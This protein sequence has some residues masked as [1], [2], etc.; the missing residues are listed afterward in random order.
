MTRAALA[1]AAVL[2][3]IS[4]T[5]DLTKVD[6]DGVTEVGGSPGY[7]RM[8]PRTGA[9]GKL[10]ASLLPPVADWA[11]MP[12]PRLYYAVHGVESGGNGA[13]Q[14]PF[15]SIAEA[16]EAAKASGYAQ[17]AVVL[18]PGTYADTVKLSGQ[19]VVLG[20][21]EAAPLELV[22][23]ADGVSSQV[24]LCNVH[25]DSLTV[26][27]G[28]ARIS[29]LGTYVNRLA[30]SSAGLTVTRLDMGSRVGFAARAYT[31]VY[32]G[33]PTAPQ[34]AALVSDDATSAMRLADGRAKVGDRTVAYLDDV[35]GA[36]TT[37]YSAIGKVGGDYA[38]LSTRL[39]NEESARKSGDASLQAAISSAKTSL[40]ADIDKVGDGW[41]AQLESL[42]SRISAS[43]GRISALDAKATDDAARLTA[44]IADV[45]TAYASA[46]TELAAGLRDEFQSCLSS[47]ESG[48]A[49]TVDARFSRLLEDATPDI[50]D[51]AVA[52][53][54]ES[55]GVVG[56]SNRLNLVTT[57]IAALEKTTSGHTAS[58]TALTARADALATRINGVQDAHTAD[59]DALATNIT[60]LSAALTD[61][62]GSL[63]GR[64]SAVETTAATQGADITSIKTVVNAIIDCLNDIGAGKT[65][66][67][68]PPGKLQ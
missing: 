26:N 50:V 56:I 51:S 16:V 1:C 68:T 18:A 15:S 8:L 29:L 48:V 58:I 19:L 12:T 25:V 63:S 3:A 28:S 9:G 47:T 65:S 30:G 17:A 14:N 55:G 54:N 4:G 42:S 35:A 22:V 67:M 11:S 6:A 20:A 13:P 44:S 62:N 37:V 49:D 39:A 66:S 45:R 41:N 23:E 61:G 52:K 34:A 21:G 31:D 24:V 60:V 59:I 53:M 38:S 27:G 33:H 64:M 40:K 2:A 5:A 10:D 46:D 57:D 32:R 7:A 36:T 43:D